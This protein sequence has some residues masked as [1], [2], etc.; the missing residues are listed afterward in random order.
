MLYSTVLD[1]GKQAWPIYLSQHASFFLALKYIDSANT[2]I[3]LTGYTAQMM[4]RR[5]I[6][7][8]NPS[9]LTLTS[10]PPAGLAID[11]PN[12][13]ITITITAAQVTTLPEMIG[14]NQGRWDILATAPDGFVEKLLY[15][16]VSVFGTVTR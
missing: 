16:P 8:S 3:P 9:L 12:G 11:A 5:T 2:V 1:Q 13:L 15:G 4:I 14:D 7:A 6:D 10:S